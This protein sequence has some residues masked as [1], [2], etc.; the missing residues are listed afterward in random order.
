MGLTNS[1]ISYTGLV[2]KYV[3]SAYDKMVLISDNIDALLHI[4]TA[5]TDGTFDDILEIADDIVTVVA[6]IEEFNGLY[7]GAIDTTDPDTV[8]D[9]NSPVDEPHPL[10]D[11]NGDTAHSGDLYYNL[12]RD[13]MY[14]F[15]QSQWNG[16]ATIARNLERFVISAAQEQEQNT[17][18]SVQINLINAYVRQSN[19]LFVFKNGIMQSS[20]WIEPITGDYQETT[21]HLV[22]FP[23]PNG[24]NGLPGLKEGDELTFGVNT[25]VST[26]TSLV[27]VDQWEIPAQ[28]NN[29]IFL[30]PNE[31]EYVPGSN[32]LD[33]YIGAQRILQLPDELDEDGIVIVQHEYREVD[34]R[35]IQFHSAPTDMEVVMRRGRIISTIPQLQQTIFQNTQPD[36]NLYAQGQQWCD[37]GKGRMFFLYVDTDSR[38]WLSMAGEETVI[39]DDTP[40]D[41]IVPD[42]I[43]IRET[44]MQDSPPEPTFY[45]K[46]ALWLKTSTMELHMLYDDAWVGDG[47]DTS[48][49]VP[50][51]D[52]HWVKIST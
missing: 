1:N 33:V 21:N 36:V 30:L 18:G 3:G 17:G 6:D 12:D 28:G 16:T 44:F 15:S 9:P 32:N 41:P 38:Q 47:G 23:A 27:E 39:V 51:D 19:N 52:P 49:D 37:T 40:L 46:G 42:P 34:P 13:Q 31:E 35:T 14:V 4:S 25:E 7:W 50:G 8:I 10:Y 22:T 11:K 26:L 48:N 45:N 2:E 5:I 24:T 43:Q 20:T 29:K